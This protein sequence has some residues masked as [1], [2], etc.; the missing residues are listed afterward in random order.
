M[1]FDRVRGIA[2]RVCAGGALR[3]IPYR[4]VP[5]I[6]DADNGMPQAADIS[7]SFLGIFPYEKTSRHR[8]SISW[9]AL[10]VV[11]AA[12]FLPKSER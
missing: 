10:P 2:A 4:V 7:N 3:G 8:E 6:V 1:G 5:Q 11:A 12:E 9:A